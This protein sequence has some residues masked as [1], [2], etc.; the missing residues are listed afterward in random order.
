MNEFLAIL[1]QLSGLGAGMIWTATVV[2][3]RVG[4]AMALLPAFGEQSVPQRVRLVLAL[5]FTAV[6][7]PSVSNQIP[8]PELGFALPLLVEVIVG[9]MLGIGLRLFVLAL[10]MAGTIAAQAMS[11]SQL[12]GG[13]GP[14]PQPAVANLL[15]MG[16]LALAV[17]AGLHVR[18]AQ[19]LILSYEML[20]PGRLP[21][22][23]DFAR[24][25]VS[26]IGQAFSL[27]FSL[28]A[29]FTIAA[30]LYNIALGVINRA[31][32]TLMVTFVGA[33]ALTLGGLMLLAIVAP[34]VLGIWL[35]G[36]QGFLDHPFRTVP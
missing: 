29:P 24:W 32:P 8:A 21:E 3:V 11:L 35:E 36:L 5:A 17:M 25:G 18:I 27:A 33:P 15:V 14:E 4:S 26:Q 30:L 10:Q 16:G 28:A 31:M 19:L 9:L 34:P 6:V 12:F 13:A 22:A 7:A 2:F 23:A 20:P 1:T